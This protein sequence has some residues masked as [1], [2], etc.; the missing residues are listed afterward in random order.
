MA[1]LFLV[2]VINGWAQKAGSLQSLSDKS[3]PVSDTLK[4]WDYSWA[5]GI[6][7]SQASYSNWSQ[8]GVNSISGTASSVFGALYRYKK[9]AYMMT[10]NLKYGKAHLEGEGTRKTDDQIVF[11]NKFNYSLNNS[12]MSLFGNVDFRT[13]FDEGYDYGG[14]QPVLISRFFAPAYFTQNTGIAYNPID[15]FSLEFGGGFKQTI[16]KDTTLSTRYGLDEGKKFRFEP[17]FSIGMNF[18]KE[19]A[20]NVKLSSSVETFTNPQKS[21]ENTDVRFTNELIG[22]VNS[23]INTTIQ[24]VMMYDNDFSSKIQTKQ[25]L[26]VGLSYTIL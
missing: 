6:N 5:A 9:F 4:G 18:D 8:G 21:I 16:V 1:G 14:D 3:V 19:I 13:Q 2:P 24:F 26:S 7:G 25:V 23:Y 15:Y 12:D 11:K 17:G 20:K 10:T 22:K